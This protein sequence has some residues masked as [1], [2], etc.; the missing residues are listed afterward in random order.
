MRGMRFAAA[1]DDWL[2]ALA[3]A[4]THLSMVFCPG[5]NRYISSITTSID[6]G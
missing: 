6:L 2:L 3:N 4:N 5:A 1:A